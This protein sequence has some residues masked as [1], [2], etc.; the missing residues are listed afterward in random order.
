LSSLFVQFVKIIYNTLK[1]S[2]IILKEALRRSLIT[3]AEAAERLGIS[4]QTL[5][6]YTGKAELSEDFVQNVKENLGID[7]N[8]SETIGRMIK[9]P[10]P[11]WSEPTLRKIPFYAIDVS[12]GDIS[13]YQDFNESPAYYIDLPGFNDCD[14]A[15]PVY[16]DSMYPKIKNGDIVLLKKINDHSIISYGEI[17]LVITAENRLLKYVRKH[18]DKSMITLLSEN[19]RFDEIEVE[20]DKVKHL[21]IYK[22]KIEKS[23]I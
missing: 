19:E 20:R 22:G 4:R 15:M 16:G 10:P 8:S 12:A 7:L 9:E 17:Y 3:Q 11:K 2:G 13:F 6:N 21:F 1:I 5:V 23:Q 18:S 14:L